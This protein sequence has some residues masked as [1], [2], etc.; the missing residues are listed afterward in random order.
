MS[1]LQ[2]SQKCCD[3]CGS[4]IQTLMLQLYV[5]SNY[6]FLSALQN[7]VQ[8]AWRR[9]ISHQRLEIKES[10][11]TTQALNFQTSEAGHQVSVKCL[12]SRAFT[13]LCD[14]AFL[15]VQDQV[16][17]FFFLLVNN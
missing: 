16:V 7:R 4:G 11:W 1:Y 3:S 10:T 9:A 17:F 12:Y 8:V 5:N 6:I 13:D 2:V 15:H 14:S